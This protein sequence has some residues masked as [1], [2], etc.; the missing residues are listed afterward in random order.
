[1]HTII[2]YNEVLFL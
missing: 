1:M 2:L